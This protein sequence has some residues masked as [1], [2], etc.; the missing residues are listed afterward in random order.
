MSYILIIVIVLAV[1]GVLL[2][3]QRMSQKDKQKKAL[4][5]QA[6]RILLRADD[7]WEVA[8][9]TA[10]FIDAPEVLDVLMDLYKYQI[11]RRDRLI[12]P[13][14]TQEL[15]DKADNFKTKFNASQVKNELKNDIE[16]NH[17][18][19]SF[20]RTSKLL[21]SANKSK[22]LSGKGCNAMRNALRR[23]LLDLEVDAYIKLG[24]AAG[25]KQ[26]PA[27]ATNY[28]KFAKKLLIESDLTFD[29]KNELVR[30]IS[31]KTQLLFGNAVEDQ[32][33]RDLK[34]EEEKEANDTHGIPR[35]LDVMTGNKKK[36]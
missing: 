16:I 17:A 14:D 25:D 24:D 29:G 4:Q 5:N 18:K 36:F 19:R 22:L 7:I 20:A 8:E 35:D 1:L 26:N 32:L 23:R 15:C 30:E 10:S 3:V 6:K 21:R 31:N 34:S 2:I 33:S 11:R 27:V 9:N 28:Y 13:A 12:T